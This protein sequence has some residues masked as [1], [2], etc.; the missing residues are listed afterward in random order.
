MPI[1]NI[2]DEFTC[3]ISHELIREPVTIEDDPTGHLY[4]KKALEEWFK[5]SNINPMT[6]EPVSSKTIKI[7]PY[8]K[9]SIKKFLT[10]NKVCSEE[11]FLQAVNSGKSENIEALNIIDSYLSGNGNNQTPLHFAALNGHVEMVA[12]LLKLECAIDAKCQPGGTTPLLLAVQNGHTAVVELLLN[13]GANHKAIANNGHYDL[14][15]SHYAA[16]S[17]NCDIINLLLDRHLFDLETKTPANATPLCIAIVRRKLNAAELLLKRGA[18]VNALLSHN[19]TPL[20]IAAERGEPTIVQL[21]LNFKAN[22]NAITDSGESPLHLAAKSNA[23]RAAQ[24]LINFNAAMNVTD[25]KGNT[26]LH[27]AAQHNATDVVKVLLQNRANLSIQNNDKQTFI[28]VASKNNKSET[29]NFLGTFIEKLGNNHIQSLAKITALE[30][31]VKEKDDKI[32][33]LRK[34]VEQ[35]SMSRSVANDLIQ[36]SNTTSTIIESEMQFASVVLKGSVSP[37]LT[38]KISGL[39]DSGNDISIEELT[40]SSMTNFF[41]RKSEEIQFTEETHKKIRPNEDDEKKMGW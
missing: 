4:E 15:V 24:V 20:H 23:Q 26:P 7:N 16:Y 5:T 34:M 9:V 40:K 33:E 37:K 11:E 32:E 19:L 2:P 8:G 10:D 35:L 21:L 36:E 3:P 27:V 22:A 38:F 6:K 1:I 39:N 14:T 17:G 12:F 13:N 41:K 25:S 29:L 28:E 18:N 31:L 30:K